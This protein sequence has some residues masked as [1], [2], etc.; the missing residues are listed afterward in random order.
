MPDAPVLQSKLQTRTVPSVH[1][2]VQRL[3]GQSV[4]G[5]SQPFQNFLSLINVLVQRTQLLG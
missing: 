2:L 4:L 3:G 5:S 1:P